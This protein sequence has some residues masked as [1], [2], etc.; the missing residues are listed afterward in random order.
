MRAPEHQVSVGGWYEFPVWNDWTLTP[1]L[2]V[3]D[4]GEHNVSTSGQDS[5]LIDGYTIVNAGLSLASEAGSPKSWE[6][7][8]GEG[9][10]P[11]ARSV[12]QAA[13]R[14]TACL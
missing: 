13:E 10:W 1:S 6:R 14:N 8:D 11:A 12:I 7:L 2:N 3:I 5:A 4:Y 9:G